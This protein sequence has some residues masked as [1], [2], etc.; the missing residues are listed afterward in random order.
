MNRL[1]KLVGYAAVW[2]AVSHT[3]KA[4]FFERFAVGAVSDSI[5]SDDISALWQHN[6]ELEL[7][8]NGDGGLKLREDGRG[9]AFEI[10]PYEG[11]EWIESTVSQ[12]RDRRVGGMSIGF[13]RI[14]GRA[15]RLASGLLVYTNTRVKL[16]EI[17]PVYSPL[18]RETSVHLAE[19]P[20]AKAEPASSAVVYYKLHGTRFAPSRS[21]S[22]VVNC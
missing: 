14:E 9:L 1:P 16:L 2:G 5:K 19:P 10:E 6:W 7:A 13:R 17:S 20:A 15:E 8:C 4:G 18:F 11:R 22:A 3:P 12:I 21:G